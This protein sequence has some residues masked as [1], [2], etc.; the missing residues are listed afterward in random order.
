MPQLTMPQLYAVV[1]H[2]VSHSKSPFIHA[3]FA[4]QTGENLEYTAIQAPLDEFESMVSDFFARGGRGLNVTLPFKE[5]AFALADQLT[6]RAQRAGAVNTLFPDTQ[7]RLVGDNTDG[8]GL[9]N[10]LCRNQGAQVAGRRVLILGAGGA[11]RGVLGPLLAQGP[12]EVVIA[13]R[14]VSKAEALQQLFASTMPE[15]AMSVSEF[16]AVDG[17]FDLIINGTSASL[18]G[19]LPPLPASAVAPHTLCYDMMYAS[20]TTVF[21]RWA[22]EQGAARTLDGLGMLV[23]QAAEAF[24]LWRHRRPDTAAVIAALRSV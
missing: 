18:A 21:N 6:E 11:V 9:V 4:L 17:A 5:R 7:G 2:P 13:N 16:A 15:V 3:Q 12:K 14:T 8:V 1:G 20:E 22:S 23:E 10:D 19:N 24:W